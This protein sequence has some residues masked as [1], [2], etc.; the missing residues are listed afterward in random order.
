[1]ALEG[2]WAFN[3][4]GS[5][6]VLDL[7]GNGRHIDLTGSNG[8][9]VS[10]GQTS[11]ALGKTGATMPQLPSSVLAACQT[12]DRTIMFDAGDT[13][14][15]WWLR[16]NDT[17]FGSGMW[18]ILNIGNMAVQARDNTGSHNLATRPTAALPVPAEWH[19]YCATYVRSTGVISIYR[20]GT[21]ANTSSFAA[22]TQLST[23]AAFIDLAEWTNTG[24][25]MDNLRLFSH[26]LTAP[27]V[28]ALAGT[29]V[30]AS[31]SSAELAGTLKKMTFLGE[32]TS[33]SVAEIVATLPKG[34]FAGEAVA[35]SETQVVATLGKMTAHIELTELVPTT[36][37]L[38]ATMLKMV[39]GVA[40]TV[41][42][43]LDVQRSLTKAFIDS[44]PIEIEL[45]PCADVRLPSGGVRSTPGTPR[46]LQT[47]RLIP[48]SHTEKP[49]R[50]SSAAAAADDG[51]QR[52]YDYTLLGEWNCEMAE[53]D[54]W[55]TPDGQLLVI[56]ALVS[57]NRYER[58]G[59]VV[60]YG[61]R[62]T[63]A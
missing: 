51:V 38:N 40:S 52:R 12:D 53:N 20:D 18:G 30:V 50:S 17:V 10:G 61:R 32:A 63:H 42:S 62:P 31:A 36:V 39:A 46:P 26:A 58:K 6:T 35:T 25:A 7:S 45:V 47:F 56:E 4:I 21:L 34:Q 5:S 1:M 28:A 41:S 11:G 60:S 24:P 43:E 19:N 44:S 22:G 49:V 48:M 9:Q 27:E 14:S 8:A 29:P 37:E 23:S 57:Y 33:N 55:E 16:F 3:D 59:L 13:F 54:Q 15:T 2:A